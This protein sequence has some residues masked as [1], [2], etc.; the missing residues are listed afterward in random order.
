[1]TRK[2]S[3]TLAIALFAGWTLATFLLE[4]RL[5]TLQRPAATQARLLYTLVANV[6]IGTLLASY[7]IRT[8][9]REGRAPVIFT[10]GLARR[11]RI[12]ASVLLGLGLGAAVLAVQGLP[13]WHPIVLVNTF[14]QVVV[15]SI[16]EVMVCWAILGTVVRN[17][18]GPGPRGMMAGLVAAALAFGLY[19]FAHSPPFNSLGMVGFLSIMGL[20][21]GLYFFV[22]RDL[23]GTVL[24]HNAVAVKG[25]T[26]ALAETDRLEF[27]ERLQW[28]LLVTGIG[29]VLVLILSDLLLMR[30]A[31]TDPG[32]SDHGGA[33]GR[34]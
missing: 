10:H 28:P 2:S 24:F 25:V 5:L 11:R 8:V 1:M 23:Y 34:T 19:H 15:V 3:V 20:V 30:P 32:G 26:T 21:T 14:L 6:L 18:V 12:A 22:A 17:S 33:N 16:A 31:L 27:Y 9:L 7:V 29:A 4:G 13:T